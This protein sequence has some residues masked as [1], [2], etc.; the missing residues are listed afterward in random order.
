M[1]GSV[2]VDRPLSPSL[3]V[4]LSLTISIFL[5]HFVSIFPYTNTTMYRLR[6]THPLKSRSSLPWTISL[7]IFVES[8]RKTIIL[9]PTVL[10][11]YTQ[12][13]II[14]F[15][16]VGLGTTCKF[17]R[18]R[19]Q[20]YDDWFIR[21]I[22]PLSRSCGH[23]SFGNWFVKNYL[24]P[25]SALTSTNER[26]EFLY[27]KKKK[28]REHH[29]TQY[30]FRLLRSV[31]CA[32]VHGYVQKRGLADLCVKSEHFTSLNNSTDPLEKSR[33]MMIFY[34]FI[35]IKYIILLLHTI[36]IQTFTTI[37]NN[38]TYIIC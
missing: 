26:T 33:R 32:M 25:Y 17:L 5:V 38:K 20:E 31:V 7:I 23:R 6:H 13:I 34:F 8:I 11:A 14:I 10:Q 27:I 15:V 4:T 29:N 28:K 22:A 1:L 16:Y 24:R 19:I 18:N 9:R 36:N 3:S 37:Q 21:S 30:S 35:I 12:K 2:V